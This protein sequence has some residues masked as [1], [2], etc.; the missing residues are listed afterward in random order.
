M[1][2]SLVAIEKGQS[3]LLVEEEDNG[4]WVFGK[5]TIFVFL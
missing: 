1:R 2:G 4:K 5:E 3:R